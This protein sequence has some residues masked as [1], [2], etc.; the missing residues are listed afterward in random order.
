MN[1]RLFAATAA[2][3]FLASAFIPVHAQDKIGWGLNAGIG[4][5]QIRDRDNDGTFDGN[6]LG[7]SLEVEY[8]FSRSF[9]LGFGGF[10]L[11][12]ADDTVNSVDT[13]IDVDAINLVGRLIFPLSD[14]V[15]V[16]G[17]LGVVNYFTD[18]EPGFGG[19][20]RLFG[21]DAVELG[22][23]MDVGGGE[24]FAFRL[25][26]RYFNGSRDETGALLTLGVN[27]RF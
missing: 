27:Y 23:G 1:K 17:R 25:E 22:I 14:S 9:A 16:Y 20:D 21:D 10:T 19:L 3:V 4:A 15:D 6:A 5:S 12:T 7:F 13:E 8:R 26:G 11:G 18:V 2:S 24:H